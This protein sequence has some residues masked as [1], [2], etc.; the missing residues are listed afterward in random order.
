MSNERGANL[1]GYRL[2]LEIVTK[3]GK[4]LS[5]MS[6]EDLIP[7][8]LNT[9]WIGFSYW[10]SRVINFLFKGKQAYVLVQERSAVGIDFAVSDLFINKNN[11]AFG[12]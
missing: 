4:T 6:Q 12:G 1:F 2:M 3:E 5:F 7:N 11:N 8:Q 10:Q 9:L